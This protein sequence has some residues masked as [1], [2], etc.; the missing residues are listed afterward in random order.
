MIPDLPDLDA[1]AVV[2]RS[3]DNAL[4]LREQEVDDLRLVLAWADL[5]SEEPTV[6]SR[7]GNRLIQLGGDGT[8]PAQ[9]LCWG[10]LAIARLTSLAST[11]RAAADALDLRHRLPRLWKLVQDRRLPVWVAR[12]VATMS[13]TLSQKSVELVDVA[14]SA[15]VDQSPGRILKITEAKV[16]EADP[17][18][19]RARLAEDATRLGVHVSQPRAGAVLDP[20]D[21]DPGSLR[22]TCKLTPG[23]ALGFDASVH[24][25]ADLLH[26]QLTSQERETTTRGE[27]ESRAVELLSHPH[28][29]AALLDGHDR[30]DLPEP[31]KRPAVIYAHIS[32]LVLSGV[33]AGVVRVEGIGPVLL[34]QLAELLRH[35][36]ITLQPV[37]D[38]ND[39][40]SV[41]A[42]EHPT[43]VKTRTLLRT[44]GD[45]F[46]HSANT[47]Y[48]RLDHDHTQPYRPPDSGGPPGQTG[49]HND[50]PITRTH[51][52]IKTHQPG[53]QLSQLGLGIYRWTTPHG[54]RRLVT[55]D[56]TRRCVPVE[57]DDGTI[58]ELTYPDG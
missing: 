50:A 56:G 40:H 29:A 36:D 16:I 43:L 38:L 3:E 47:G 15:A 7:G 4:A 46:P 51:H 49:D 23:V 8:P 17:D 20:A 6:R 32:D 57:T 10:E 9:E 21:G 35:R 44:L 52:R 19:H 1:A 39:A 45:V 30:D 5:H 58:L 55:P 26:D 37:I 18:A 48:R 24:E 42:Y 31:K 14:V 22:V 13:R 25:V 2:R 41:N 12:K 28:A 53:Y 54:L 33:L 27:L 11:K 34:D